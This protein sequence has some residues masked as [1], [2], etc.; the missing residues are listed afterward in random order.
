MLPESDAHTASAISGKPL[1]HPRV[2]TLALAVYQPAE[3]VWGKRVSD[4]LAMPCLMV[5]LTFTPHKRPRAAL[6]RR[7]DSPARA[8]GRS[9]VVWSLSGVALEKAMA[10]RPNLE[11]PQMTSKVC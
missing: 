5:A 11:S 3:T 9:G 10:A 4:L 6:W 8:Q 2:P 1:E 7:P